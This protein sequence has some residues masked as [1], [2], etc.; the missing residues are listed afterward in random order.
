MRPARLS[1]EFLLRAAL[2]PVFAALSHAFQWQWLRFITSQGILHLSSVFGISRV[3]VSPDTISG[4]GTLFHFVV[5]CTFVDVFMGSIP[6]LW[7]RR[8]GL[9]GNLL[10]LLV[11]AVVLFC[12]NLIRLEISQIIYSLGVSWTFADEILGGVAYFAVWLAIWRT[13]RWDMWDPVAPPDGLVA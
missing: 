4:Q 2:V 13:R 9:L 7:D 3:R 10:R 1:R 12:F 8:K 5:A 11:A 6:L